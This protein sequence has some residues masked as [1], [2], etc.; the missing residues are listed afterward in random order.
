[1]YWNKFDLSFTRKMYFKESEINK[2]SATKGD[3]L[4]CEG[5]DFG[6]AA[7]WRYDYNVCFQ[8]HI[9]RLRPLGLLSVE[10]YFYIF[11]LYK[12]AN[13]LEGKGI[14]IQGLSSS[15]L[16]ELMVPLPPY[17]EQLRIVSKIKELFA[18]IDVIQNSLE[19]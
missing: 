14:A 8:N 16:H 12:K 7:I 9:H 19:Q 1:L 10:F 18:K 11:Y 15:A 17:N 13:L 6:R 5:G 4:I 2:Y 3:L